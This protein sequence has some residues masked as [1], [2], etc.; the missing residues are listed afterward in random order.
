MHNCENFDWSDCTVH[1]D[2]EC[3]VSVC[4]ECER[5]VRDCGGED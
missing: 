2:T 1:A 3:Y 4:K 5:E